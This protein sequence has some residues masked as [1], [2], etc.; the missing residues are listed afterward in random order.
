MGSVQRTFE[1]ASDL[2]WSRGNS[3]EDHPGTNSLV[4]REKNTGEKT[5]IF[6]LVIS[7]FI[8]VI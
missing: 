4:N 8:K 2:K 3:C 7:V 1:P 5:M 6:E